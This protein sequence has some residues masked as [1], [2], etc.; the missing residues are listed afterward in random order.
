MY[1]HKHI[2][3]QTV[4]H[5]GYN[6]INNNNK[7]TNEC[8]IK[9][10]SCFNV[11]FRF[12]LLPNLSNAIA[13]VQNSLVYMFQWKIACQNQSDEF[14]CLLRCWRFDF[15]LSCLRIKKNANETEGNIL[16]NSRMKHWDWQGAAV[17]CTVCL[18]ACWSY[19]VLY[20][21]MFVCIYKNIS[22]ESYRYTSLQKCPWTRKPFGICG[23]M[24]HTSIILMFNCFDSKQK[25][26]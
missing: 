25:C 19:H 15:M 8:C 7:W 6:N 18:L 24:V 17:Y 10:L 20:I 16:K 4:S 21:H 13:R 3:T 23:R 11:S 9:F 1:R 12:R 5:G 22:L 2:H 14:E 26:K